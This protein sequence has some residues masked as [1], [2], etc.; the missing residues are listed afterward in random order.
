MKVRV[1]PP[2]LAAK[3]AAGEVVERPASA[4][5]ELVENS[6][7]AGATRVH[8][9]IK[10]GGLEI[11]RVTD[12]GGGIDPDD[13]DVVFERYATSK[14][15][16]AEDLGAISTLGFRG[17]AL[18]SIASVS[19]MTLLTRPG[20]SDEGVLVE[21]QGGEIAKREKRAAPIGTTVTVRDLFKNVPARRKFLRSV[22]SE[23]SRIQTLTTRYA[24][25]YPEVR[26]SL[27]IDGSQ[28]FSAQGSGQL[29]EV[30]ASV[31][32][33]DI[34]E[35]MLD[36]Q[37]EGAEAAS[38]P[39]VSG[40][41]TPPSVTRANRS[42]VTFFVNRRW[43]QSRLLGYA[44]EQAYHGF[45]PGKRYP[46]AIVNLNVPLEEIDVNVHPAKTEVRFQKENQVFSSV[47]R[48]VRHT[49]SSLSPIPSVRS[50]TPATHGESEERALHRRSFW[51]T[52]FGQKP[53]RETYEAPS[54]MPPSLPLKRALPILRPLGQAQS[55]YI[56][57]EGPDG[58]YLIDQ[59]AAHERIL[60]E[61]IVSSLRKNSSE[62]QSVLEPVTVQ[63]NP[64][65]EEMVASKLGLL[66][67]AGFHLEAFGPGTY[68]IRGVPRAVGSEEPKEALT[69]TLDLL[70]EGGGFE[71]WQERMA[72]SIACHSAIRAGKTLTEA[73]MEE[74][75]RQ[76]EASEQ[77][78]TCPHGRP[79]MIHLS[80]GQLEREFKR[81]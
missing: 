4:V 22:S 47:Q 2:D 11:I 40:L 34:A 79:T 50:T 28:V 69:K 76:L 81:R 36:I 62:S 6:L 63:L 19:S 15:S 54:D 60:F 49:L 58:V 7:D 9:E 25:A 33:V 20:G 41:I 24:M 70:M 30:A 65:Q 35:G 48:T 64:E 67:E 74:V 18:P 57:A 23:A 26:F 16:S 56:I 39:V 8:V 10:G 3:I 73:E 38:G 75:A 13:A 77:P 52:E 51:H 44:L 42:Y 55:T 78:H 29:R 5:K 21:L 37:A 14:L 66:R 32:G 45:L 53:Q 72:Y 68:V 17:E 80:S 1:L 61:Q 31:Y 46:I 71:D 43:V 59:H 12:N 27:A